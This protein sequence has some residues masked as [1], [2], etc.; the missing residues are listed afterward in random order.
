MSFAST[1]SIPEPKSNLVDTI[2]HSIFPSPPP[3]VSSDRYTPEFDFDSVYC[4]PNICDL[5][6]PSV[7]SFPSALSPNTELVSPR[8]SIVDVS[9]IQ[10]LPPSSSTTGGF[11]T[12]AESLGNYYLQRYLHYRALAACVEKDLAFTEYQL[13][14]PLHSQEL[15]K[16]FLLDSD[17]AA[18]FSMSDR[19]NHYPVSSDSHD[20]DPSAPFGHGIHQ[21]YGSWPQTFGASYHNGLLP[22]LALPNEQD[23]VLL[24]MKQNRLAMPNHPMLPS[25]F[26]PSFEPAAVDIPSL[27]RQ[28]DSITSTW[29]N[30]STASST[31]RVSDDATSVPESTDCSSHDGDH[32]DIKV[33]DQTNIKATTPMVPVTNVNGGGRGYVPGLTPDDPKKKH[34]CS[35]CGRGFVRAFNLKSHIQTHNP[36]R[37]KPYTCPHPTCK[38]SFSRLHDLERHRQGVHSDGPLVDAKRQGISPAIARAQSRLQERAKLGSL[39]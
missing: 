13:E 32:K 6:S 23:P 18:A 36:L 7:A 11:E 28:V 30:S 3:S 15:Q 22:S 26:Q 38:R 25:F 20:L 16:T 14:A 35:V 33:F 27:S 29:T 10:P 17:S 21:L 37:P 19:P 2:P 1:F 8:S 9:Q 24:Q 12:S 5:N 31:Q 4:S 39:I 34:K